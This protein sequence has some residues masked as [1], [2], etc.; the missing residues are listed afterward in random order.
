M[1]HVD[2]GRV[3]IGEELGDFFI[4]LHQDVLN[5]LVGEASSGVDHCPGKAGGADLA[6]LVDLH[7]TALGQAVDLG[8]Q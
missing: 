4:R 7:H 5:L 1:E 3:F 2:N 8:H 6:V